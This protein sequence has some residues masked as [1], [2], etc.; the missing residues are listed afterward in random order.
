MR[1]GDSGREVAKFGRSD[2][3]WVKSSCAALRDAREAD[4][5]WR[6]WLVLIAVVDRPIGGRSGCRESGCGGRRV[7]VLILEY[8]AKIG[9]VRER[10]TSVGG[11]RGGPRAHRSGRVVVSAFA[12]VVVARVLSGEQ[13]VTLPPHLILALGCEPTAESTV[14]PV[15]SPLLRASG[16]KC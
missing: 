16:D 8:E 6:R 5:G 4:H 3:P 14:R 2:H 1:E 9:V 7:V 12:T 10:A 13:A 15:V 11:L